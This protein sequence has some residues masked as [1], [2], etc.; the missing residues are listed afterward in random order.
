MKVVRAGVLGDGQN[1]LGFCIDVKREIKKR[2][3]RAF[4]VFSYFRFLLSGIL[5]NLK[6]NIDLKTIQLRRF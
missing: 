4:F 3:S 1:G 2:F 6:Q 5:L